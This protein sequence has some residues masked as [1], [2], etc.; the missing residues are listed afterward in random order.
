MWW[1]LLHFIWLCQKR[2][3]IRILWAVK[4][5]ELTNS[6]KTFL[7]SLE[8]GDISCLQALKKKTSDKIRGVN[9]RAEIKHNYKLQFL[10]HFFWIWRGVI[11]NYH[12]VGWSPSLIVARPICA[13][14]PLLFLRFSSSNSAQLSSFLLTFGTLLRTIPAISHQLQKMVLEHKFYDDSRSLV[15]PNFLQTGYIIVHSPCFNNEEPHHCFILYAR[16]FFG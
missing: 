1:N 9:D 11:W 13:R 5:K 8:C 7:H 14:C 4:V 12:S 10:L 16:S 3:L 15:L 2:L 6:S